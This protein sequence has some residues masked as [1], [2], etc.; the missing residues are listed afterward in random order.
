MLYTA[1]LKK[2]EPGLP[3]AKGQDAWMNKTVAHIHQRH[4]ECYNMFLNRIEEIRS[5]M[6]DKMNED[7][8]YEPG[9]HITIDYTVHDKAPEENGEIDVIY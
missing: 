4:G 6:E 2:S 7:P 3:L 1:V 9:S 8:R 5:L